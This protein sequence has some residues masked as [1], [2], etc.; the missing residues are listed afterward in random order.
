MDQWT[1]LSYPG[2]SAIVVML[3]G[4]IKRMFPAW[5][6]GKEPLLGLSFSV[7]LGVLAKLTVTGA[8]SDVQWVPHTVA[9]VLTAFMAKLGHDYLLNQVVK[10]KDDGS[11]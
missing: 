7:V 11:K 3:I 8:F 9:L 10:G 5:T 1:L 4:G 6:D 2:I